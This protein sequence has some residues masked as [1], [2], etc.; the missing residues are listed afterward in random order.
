MLFRYR[1]DKIQ[2]EL[3]KIEMDRQLAEMQRYQKRE[4]QVNLRRYND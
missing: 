1:E 4:D 3:E 2:R